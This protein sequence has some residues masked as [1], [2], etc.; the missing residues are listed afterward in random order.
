[1]NLMAVPQILIVLITVTACEQN[2][3]GNSST[4]RNGVASSNSSTV[5]NDRTIV[6]PLRVKVE[7]SAIYQSQLDV[8]MDRLASGVTEENK[9]KLQSTVLQSMV[10]T[11]VLADLA[12]QQLNE[13]ESRVI[14]AK[15]RNFRDE[16]L[17]QSYIGKN[18][19]AEPVTVEMVKQYYQDHLSDYKTQG[20]INFEFMVTTSDRLDDDTVS[21]VI[22]A[23]SKA[24][25]NDNWKLYITELKQQNLPVEFNAVSMLPTSINKVLRSPI[26]KLAD[27]EV[28]DVV[29][30]DYIYV[31]KLIH[32]KSE[33][34][35]PLQQVSVGIRK[36]LAPQKFKQMLTQ[37]IDKALS[38]K[39]VEFIE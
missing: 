37:H 19:V 16:L 24:K 3:V 10:R 30:G 12:E 39:K 29:F 6:D 27:G 18:M 33:L 31:V 8:M 25:N 21:Q 36:K 34:V 2:V 5:G 32:R 23:F 4:G 22:S 15:L 20:R 35:K 38:G 28:S 7:D 1:M 9:A 13:E 11:R 26:D 14:N 17:V